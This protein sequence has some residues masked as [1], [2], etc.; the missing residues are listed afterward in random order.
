MCLQ[1]GCKKRGLYNFLGADGRYCA[2][3]RQEG[4]VNVA[5]KKCEH[6]DCSKIP[7]YNLPE[8]TKAK[9]CNEHKLEGMENVKSKKCEHPDCSKIPNYNIPGKPI[10]G[11]VTS[12]N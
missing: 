11:F 12:I 10:R 3:H 1:N 9:F 5:N 6:P 8:E 7:N 2:E 4:M